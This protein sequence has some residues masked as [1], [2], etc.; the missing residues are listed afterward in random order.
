MDFAGLG[1]ESGSGVAEVFEEFLGELSLRE[2]EKGGDASGGALESGVFGILAFD[3]GI[4]KK[5]STCPPLCPRIRS[6][7][8]PRF[9][10]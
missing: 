2:G 4:R 9:P 6:S 1:E 5:N 10:P 8:V 7:F 3:A